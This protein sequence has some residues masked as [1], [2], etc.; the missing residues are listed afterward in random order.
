[1]SAFHPTPTVNSRLWDLSRCANK[2]HHAFR[3]ALSETSRAHSIKSRANGPSIRFLSVM[4]PTCV[5]VVEISTGRFLI[6]A[7]FIDH[8]TLC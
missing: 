1:M 5:L 7:R 3:A 4:M 8:G 6:N 2:R